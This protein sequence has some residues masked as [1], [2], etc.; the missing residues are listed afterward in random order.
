ME[1]FKAFQ[2][3]SRLRVLLVFPRY[4]RSFGTFDHAF[5]LLGKRA[6][7]PPQ[8]LLLLAAL[9][10]DQW[11]VRFI[12]E[13]TRPV[14]DKDLASADVVLLSGMHVQRQRIHELAARARQ[15]GKLTVLGGPS[16][17][18]APEY[19]PDIDIL[20][21]GEVGDGTLALFTQ[22][23]RSTARP[24]IQQIFQTTE[25][26]PLTGFPSPAYRLAEMHRYLLGSIQFSSGC[27]F[28]CEFCDIPGLYGRNPRVKTPAQI[29]GELDQLARYGIESV[30]FVDDNFIANPKAAL[31]LLSHIV[32]W[33]RENGYRLR[34]SC[35]ASL[36]L[37]SFTKVLELMREA[38]FMTVFCG[39]E[40]PEPAA[41][42]AMRKMQNLR[43][44][45]LESIQTLNRHGLEVASGIILGLDT[46]TAETPQ[47][48]IDFAEASQVPLMTVNLLYALPKT[49]LHLRLAQQGR[50]STQPG[51]ESNV[52]FLAPYE[53][54]VERWR[55]VI[56]HIYEPGNLYARF[57]AQARSTY[58]N[59]FCP[60]QHWRSLRWRDLRRAAR[61]LMRI[62]WHVG[63]RADYRREFWRMFWTRA[64]EGQIEAIFHIAIV[65]HHLIT[66]AREGI[67]GRMQASNYSIPD[68][69]T[70]TRGIS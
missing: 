3:H 48:M 36:N 2:P 4:A 18:A 67:E 31:E 41:L 32:E 53:A 26:L 5:P 57:A 52:V 8:G 47:A 56:A 34:F 63:V 20:H 70:A 27:P 50:I 69:D 21:C 43:R 25:R 6:F 19:Y 54:V 22:L 12:D 13:N 60:P 62:I 44:P 10:P 65:A 66:Y 16:A 59:R 7:M 42:H 49:P 24:P 38:W 39:T 46:D 11:E 30:Y 64:R 33:Q 61:I 55:R 1:S 45:I 37:S 28:T 58:P 15:A 40:S 17:S 9:L 51:R 35:E 29:L 14:T 23:D 68:M